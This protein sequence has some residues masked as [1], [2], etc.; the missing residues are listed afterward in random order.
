MC[1]LPPE[2]SSD[3]RERCLCGACRYSTDPA[4]LNVRICHC[5]R[6]QK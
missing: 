1:I 2:W 3:D 6:C 5:H 4:P